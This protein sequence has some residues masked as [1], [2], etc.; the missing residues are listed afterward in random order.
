VAQ[1]RRHVRY[2]L[3]LALTAALAAVLAIAPAGASAASEPPKLTVMTQNLYLG[4]SL[5]PALEAATPEEFIEA[6]ARIY[7]TVQ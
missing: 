7:A 3:A 1:T 2:R 6:V 4:S 5:A